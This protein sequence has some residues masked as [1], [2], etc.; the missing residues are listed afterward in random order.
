MAYLYLCESLLRV[1]HLRAPALVVGWLASVCSTV[2]G[3]C[4]YLARSLAASTYLG[5]N[6]V[7]GGFINGMAINIFNGRNCKAAPSA[8]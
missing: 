2:Y 1:N 7:R 5:T 8:P 6:Q 4:F 3:A